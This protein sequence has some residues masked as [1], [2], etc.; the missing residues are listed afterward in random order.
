MAHELALLLS[1]CLISDFP[2][3]LF[4]PYVLLQSPSVCEKSIDELAE[5]KMIEEAYTKFLAERPELQKAALKSSVAAQK[6]EMAQEIERAKCES[7]DMEL[8]DTDY[9]IT[10]TYEPQH[11]DELALAAG[12]DIVILAKP[13]GGWWKG[14]SGGEEGWFPANHVIAVVA[15]DDEMDRSFGWVLASPPPT[16][17]RPRPYA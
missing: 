4:S 11:T 2:P 3:P 1:P 6:I 7:H 17:I 5:I 13:N 14:R 15:E 8:D 16:V 12:K 10:H 9:T